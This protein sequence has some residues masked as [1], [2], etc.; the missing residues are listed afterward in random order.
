MA[1]MT[2]ALSQVAAGLGAKADAL[3][4]QL[5]LVAAAAEAQY[6]TPA[7]FTP[8]ASVAG[9]A[10]RLCHVVCRAAQGAAVLPEHGADGG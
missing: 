1:P 6:C 5:E 9:W 7:V 8:S 10:G 3:S 4:E 2:A